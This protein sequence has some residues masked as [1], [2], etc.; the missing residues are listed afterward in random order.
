MN[1]RLV[2]FPCCSSGPP[3]PVFNCTVSNHSSDAFLIACQPGFHGGLPQNFS[4][5][6]F[7]ESNSSGRLVIHQIFAEP[8]FLLSSLKTNMRYK[9]SI[10]SINAKGKS[11]D[12]IVEISTQKEPERQLEVKPGKSTGP[13]TFSYF[14]L[15]SHIPTEFFY[16]FLLIY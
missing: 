1:F 8:I 2:E 14:F 3:E 16:S 9:A 12:V 4:L 7:E 15:P 13:I 6:F 5:H 10:A 11:D